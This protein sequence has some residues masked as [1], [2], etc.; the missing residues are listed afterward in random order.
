M[1][2]YCARQRIKRVV[3]PKVDTRGQPDEWREHGS[4]GGASFVSLLPGEL[5]SG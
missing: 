4:S 2:E 3:W 5:S 1:G